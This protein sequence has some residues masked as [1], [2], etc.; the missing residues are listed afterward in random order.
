MNFH[1]EEGIQKDFIRKFI[2]YVNHYAPE[3]LLCDSHEA[4]RSCIVAQEINLL[5]L[6][7]VGLQCPVNHCFNPIDI[8]EVSPSAQ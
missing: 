2:L 1:P 6:W 3:T 8:L 7:W 4:K 5:I